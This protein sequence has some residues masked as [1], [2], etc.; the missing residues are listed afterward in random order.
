MVALIKPRRK[1]FTGKTD[2]EQLADD[3]K[4]ETVDMLKK[5][6]KENNCNVE[7]LTFT[8]NNIGV[9]NVRNLTPEEIIERDKNV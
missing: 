5:V 7:D 2:A 9:V 1:I 4:K 6:A 3:F 8:V